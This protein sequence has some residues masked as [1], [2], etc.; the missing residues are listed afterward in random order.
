[1]NGPLDPELI[2]EAFERLGKAIGELKKAVLQNI[3][4]RLW[5]YLCFAIGLQLIFTWDVACKVGYDLWC[6]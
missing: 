5:V 1:M 4:G 3:R 2:S 6:G